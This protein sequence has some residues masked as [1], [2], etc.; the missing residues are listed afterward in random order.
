MATVA[1]TPESASPAPAAPRPVATGRVYG[2]VGE[3]DTAAEL[4]HAAEVVRD[5]GFKR[6]DVHSP[7]PIHGMDNAMGLGKSV[8]SYIVLCGGLTGFTT[9]VLLTFIPSTITY[10]LI[11]QGKPLNFFTVPAFFPIMFELTVLFS[12]FAA[13]FGMLAMNRL[14][15][16]HHPLFNHERFARSTDDGFFI[17]IEATDPRFIEADV[18]ELLESVGAQHITLV[19]DHD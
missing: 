1:S 15:R 16:W 17:S 8:V 12:A 9:A 7:F 19:H 18:R 10:P 6:W 3:F 11:V 5:R 4:Y 2:L 13:V 14:P